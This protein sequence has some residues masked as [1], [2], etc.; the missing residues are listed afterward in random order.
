MKY[1]AQ[2]EGCG[3][4]RKVI[5][6]SD[7]EAFC[8]AKELFQSEDVIIGKSLQKMFT[9]EDQKRIIKESCEIVDKLLSAI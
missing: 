1:Y 6:D 4:V 2:R 7:E 9:K 8:K 5:A 3:T